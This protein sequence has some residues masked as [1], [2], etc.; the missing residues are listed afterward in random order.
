MV[1]LGN[2]KFITILKKWHKKSVY[3]IILSF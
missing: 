2:V 1:R 3:I